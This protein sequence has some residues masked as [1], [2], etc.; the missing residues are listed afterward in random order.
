MFKR[1]IKQIL[2]KP[3]STLPL[4]MMLAYLIWNLRTI[5]SGKHFSQMETRIKVIP[6][7]WLDLW[8]GQLSTFCAAL[9]ASEHSDSIGNRSTLSSGLLGGYHFWGVPP[10]GYRIWDTAISLCCLMSWFAF[11]CTEWCLTT[12]S[13]SLP[14]DA[15]RRERRKSG[16]R[17]RRRSSIGCTSWEGRAAQFWKWWPTQLNTRLQQLWPNAQWLPMWGHPEH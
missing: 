13:W 4:M 2:T 8:L 16:R 10:T 17:G 14:G 12:F 9:I 15:R 5:R 11:S 1:E 3:T 7:T 6:I